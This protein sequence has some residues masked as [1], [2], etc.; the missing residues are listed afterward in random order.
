MSRVVPLPDHVASAD[1]W[2]AWPRKVEAH[3]IWSVRARQVEG[4][5]RSG[6]LKLYS[7]PDDTTRVDPD[8][9]RD[10]FGEP[11]VIP[12]K[13]RD[14]P[15][16]ERARR[17]AEKASGIDSNDPV[18][19]MFRE[20]VTM[21]RDMHKESIGLLR[22]VSDPLDKLLKAYEALIEKQAK[23]I[24]ELE[25]LQAESAEMHSALLDMSQD[26]DL[27]KR[28]ADAAEKRKDSA[29]QLLKDHVPGLI[30]LYIEGESLSAWARRIPRAVAEAL[31]D[32]GGLS[33]S[34]ADIIRRAA[35]LKPKPQAP[36][37]QQ[38]QQQQQETANGHA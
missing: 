9:M 25:T 10:L 16:E 14:L 23:R 22:V 37:E 3:T 20:A 15:K 6:K 12:G 24:V 13:D 28:A 30:S 36:P 5:V 32:D 2:K 35:G 29:L 34:D 18:V 11:G 17:M 26:R 27:K 1:E 7:C 4:Y 19:F 21:M 33:E 8:Q 31:V 38:Q